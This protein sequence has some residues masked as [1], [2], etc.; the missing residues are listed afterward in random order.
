M[1]KKE[2]SKEPET[3]KE[4]KLSFKEKLHLV[5]NGVSKK[6]LKGVFADTLQDLKKPKE[7]GIFIVSSIVP[8]GWVGYAAYRIAKYKFKHPPANDNKAEEAANPKPAPKSKKQP[9]APK[10]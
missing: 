5:F 7:I 9:K 10:P 8:G 4:K 2:P 1:S 3:P 6:E